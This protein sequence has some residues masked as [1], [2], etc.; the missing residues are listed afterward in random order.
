M[1]GFVVTSKSQAWNE[2]MDWP[3]DT[4]TW[5]GSFQ[6][7]E[8]CPPLPDTAKPYHI[9]DAECSCEK[10]ATE[11]PLWEAGKQAEEL[12]ERTRL[13]DF[14]F[15]NSKTACKLHLP[16][17]TQQPLLW[18]AYR[19]AQASYFHAVRRFEGRKEP[20]HFGQGPSSILF[21]TG[22]LPNGQD[23]GIHPSLVG[24]QILN[25]KYLRNKISHPESR[26]LE[27]LDELI[28]H[29]Q[30][31]AVAMRDE[32]RALRLRRLRD[33]LQWKAVQDVKR[34]DLC[35]ADLQKRDWALHHQ[36]LC[37]DIVGRIRLDLMTPGL[38]RTV[39]GY[40]KVLVDIACAWKMRY[41]RLGQKREYYRSNVCRKAGYLRDAGHG[42]RASVSII[43]ERPAVP[44]AADKKDSF[45]YNLAKE[46]SGSEEEVMIELQRLE[47]IDLSLPLPTPVHSDISVEDPGTKE[48][49][50]WFKISE[51]PRTRLSLM[52]DRM[53]DG[54]AW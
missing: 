32:G 22:R 7:L 15:Y 26:D 42:R 43:Q 16:F 21:E 9:Y 13:H 36:R 4:E 10:C 40:G 23:T 8:I 31:L 12:G 6:S 29:A 11:R 5:P 28:Y 47:A 27:S 19:L 49:Y 37:E 30:D 24:R 53:L 46:L 52:Y 50:P 1:P 44:A 25:M 34:L 45:T 14:K 39:E 20:Y 54:A 48:E 33:Q 2:R 3:P 41:V 35:L 51:D 38:H 17:K 18:K